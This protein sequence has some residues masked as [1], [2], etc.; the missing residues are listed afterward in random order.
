LIILF[1]SRG[2]SIPRTNEF[3]ALMTL[4]ATLDLLAHPYNARLFPTL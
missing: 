3:I 1:G 4:L 2:K